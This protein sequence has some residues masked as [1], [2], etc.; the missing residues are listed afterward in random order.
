MTNAMSELPPDA[1]GV[2]LYPVDHVLAPRGSMQKDSLGLAILQRLLAEGESWSDPKY[3]DNPKPDAFR[4]YLRANLNR[5]VEAAW[6]AFIEIDRGT[7]PSGTYVPRG[8]Q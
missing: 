8:A 6:R 4:Y 1:A 3:G 5:E 2:H 7:A